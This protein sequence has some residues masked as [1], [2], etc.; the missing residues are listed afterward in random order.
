MLARQIRLARAVA[1]HILSHAAFELLPN[2]GI[3]H[4]FIIVLFRARDDALNRNLVHA[5]NRTGRIY[6]SG[7][8]W[9][10]RPASRIAVSNWRTDEKRDLQVIKDV[11]E[12]VAGQRIGGDSAEAL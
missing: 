5:I 11:L 8:A 7:T 6:V 2:V 3:Q 12:E 1:S 10:G 4:V 9:G